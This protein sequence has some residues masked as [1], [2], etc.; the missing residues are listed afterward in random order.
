MLLRRMILRPQA[1]FASEGAQTIAGNNCLMQATNLQPLPILPL[2]A[3]LVHSSHLPPN[4]NPF[5]QCCRICCT[6]SR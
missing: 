1:L 2:D 5:R 3:T 4:P 6:L